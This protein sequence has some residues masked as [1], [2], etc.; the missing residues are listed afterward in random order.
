MGHGTVHRWHCVCVCDRVTKIRR[1][2]LYPLL[3][4]YYK[5]IQLI[6]KLKSFHFFFFDSFLCFSVLWLIIGYV[7]VGQSLT[8]CVLLPADRDARALEIISVN[9]LLPFRNL[10]PVSEVVC[11]RGQ[12][13]FQ[14]RSH[15]IRDY[16]IV[17]TLNTQP[18]SSSASHVRHINILYDVHQ[19]ILCSAC[20]IFVT[21]YV[22]VYLCV[23]VCGR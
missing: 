22:S 10:P 23:C 16:V 2:S 12:T 15:F 19:P 11:S 9:Q 7:S 4:S 17:F 13:P 20:I 1:P 21:E 8:F 14:I 5:L 6:Y 3:Y 18:T